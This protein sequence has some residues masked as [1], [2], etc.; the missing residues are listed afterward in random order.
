[1]YDYSFSLQLAV[2]AVANGIDVP[3]WVERQSVDLKI[4][5]FDRLYQ[6]TIIINNRSDIIA[7]LRLQKL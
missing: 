2:S 7:I 1:M 6:D 4:C 3:V 5:V